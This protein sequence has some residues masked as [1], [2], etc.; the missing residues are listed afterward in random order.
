L[1]YPWTRQTEGYE[2]EK[3]GLYNSEK[4]HFNFAR[5]LQPPGDKRKS[6]EAEIMDWADDITYA[7]HDAEDFYRAGLMPLDRLGS[8]DDKSERQHFFDG[9]YKRPE[10]AKQLGTNSRTEL[11]DA[12][13][14]VVTTFPISQPYTGSREHRSRLRDFSSNLIGLFVNAIEL[15]VPSKEDELFVQIKPLQKLQVRI[16]KA[17][18]WFYVIYNPALATQQYGQRRMIRE[19]FEIFGDAASAADEQERNIIPFAFRDEI[20]ENGANPAALTR[21]VTDMLSGMTEQGITKLYRR[22]TGVD[23]GSILDYRHGG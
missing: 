19:L 5:K 15:H 2:K 6:A 17:L 4:D 10:L 21:I 9:M 20:Y 14:K 22:L 13:E 3:Y 11:E 16:L 8:L 7:V 18:T 23:M 1:K 12:F